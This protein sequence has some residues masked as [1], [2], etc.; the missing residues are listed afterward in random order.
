MN[1]TNEQQSAIDFP[2][3]DIIVSAAAGSGKTAVMS[4]RI[5]NR[6]T[7]E[8]YVDIDRILVVTYTKAA[9]SEIKERVMKKILD[10]LSDGKNEILSNQLVKIQN[11]HFCTIHSFCLDLIR[12]NFYI[13]GIDPNV[14]IADESETQ[15]LKQ[16]AVNY[17]INE[18]YESGDEKFKNIAAFYYRKKDTRLAELIL[19]T[20]GFSRTMP[21]SDKW[22]E[23]LPE[24]YENDFK[25]KEIAY[26]IFK[27]TIKYIT[28]TLN[29]AVELCTKQGEC[30]A[31]INLL[32]SDLETYDDLLR[33]N[34]YERIYS[35]VNDIKFKKWVTDKNIDSEFTALIKKI[36]DDAKKEFDDIKKKYFAYDPNFVKK[37]NNNAASDIKC[38][39]SLVKKFADKF[40][41]L[42]REANLIDFSDFE[43]M[44]LRLLKNDDGTPTDT[45]KYISEQFDEIYIDEYQDCNN[46]QNEIFK[47]ISGEYRGKPN[48]FC[49][50]DMKQSIYSFRDANPLLFKQKIDSYNMFDGKTH[51]EHNKILLNSNFR[52]RK[53]IL[54]FVNTLFYRTMSPQCGELEYNND[55]MLSYGS[56]FEDVNPDTKYID[57]DIIDKDNGFD[58]FSEIAESNLTKVEAEAVHVAEKIKKYIS[59][60]YVL[61]DRKEK[62]TRTAKYSDIVVLMRGMKSSAPIF[63]RI[64]KKMEI[65]VYS[66]KSEEY[67]DS[68]E[69]VFLTSLLKII[70]NPDDDISLAAAM[71]NPVFGFDENDFL[72]IRLIDKNISFY[73]CICKYK[74]SADDELSDKISEFLCKINDFYE[75]SR[76]ME[77]DEL[78]NYV[79][80]K[81][82]FYTYLSTF[83]DSELK[84]T[85]V[86]F[87]IQKAKDFEKTN[88]K[89]IFS[90]IR[91]IDNLKMSDDTK[92]ESARVLGENDNVVRIMSIHKSKGLEFPIVFLARLG[93]EIR[94]KEDTKPAIYHSELGIGA[95]SYSGGKVIAKTKSLNKIIVRYQKFKEYIS[96]EMR[97]LYVAL[98]RPTEKL[99]LSGVCSLATKV[100]SKIEYQLANQ[101]ERIDPF[102][103]MKSKNFLEIILFG[104]MRSGGYQADSMSFEMKK[105]DDGCKYNVSLIN[106]NEIDF[107][108]NPACDMNWEDMYE[109]C[110]DNYTKISNML[111]FE[112]PYKASSYLPSNMTVTEVKRL[113]DD[114]QDLLYDTVSLETPKNF[115][116]SKK[117]Y[118][119]RLG[120]LVHKI[121]EKVNFENIGDENCLDLLIDDMKSKR[122]IDDNES[123][124]I[125]KDRINRFFSSKLAERM[126][127]NISSLRREFSF[128]IMIDSSEIF[129]DANDDNMI[130][131]GTIDAFFIESD[132]NAVI[133]DYKT[134]SVLNVNS[135]DIAEKYKI[136][137]DCYAKAVEKMLNIK[138]KE[139]IIYLFATGETINL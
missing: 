82:N 77:T 47:Y 132:E 13:L 100:L 122:I 121:V 120:T 136:Q 57:I 37:I 87:L 114:D 1:W 89:G 29:Y 3:S 2:V 54:N 129:S 58:T 53:E 123:E 21:S 33:I 50:G 20:Y 107:D 95:D 112:Y 31:Y 113:S 39:V 35:C 126:K 138:V 78:I 66:D 118:G 45:A 22:L 80:I 135:K 92:V 119:A 75:K 72:K 97:V 17:V 70:D 43:H 88:F 12:K 55:E 128:K 73:S 48:V 76:Y 102:L 41:E 19:S 106:M 134:D 40:D 81:I 83:T 32:S 104:I 111:S 79:V 124:C 67:F 9:A 117:I 86:R 26:D 96:E 71:K 49:V 62:K 85:N 74:D 110:T 139:K 116:S 137:I 28:S 61:Y 63:E 109:S 65:P 14:K 56:D 101:D 6:L 115:A 44:A 60:G 108:K 23:M 130:I 68:E 59:D 99:V 93:S 7:A 18:G 90:F 10:K 105:Y 24:L 52:S 42:K 25:V 27:Q 15:M 69:I 94:L 16:N 131:Q 51:Y 91:Y 30:A 127:N 125:P 98:T 46:L 133:V 64:F 4:E 11:S 38:L 103:I 36:R 8:D 34:D 84:K 5:I